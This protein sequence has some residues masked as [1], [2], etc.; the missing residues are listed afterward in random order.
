MTSHI[1]PGCRRPPRCGHA[2]ATGPA[3]ELF[4]E[5]SP[6]ARF[7]LFLENFGFRACLRSNSCDLFCFITKSCIYDICPLPCLCSPTLFCAENRPSPTCAGE[8]STKDKKVITVLEKYHPVPKIWKCALMDKDYPFGVPRLENFDCGLLVQFDL[9]ISFSEIWIM[10]CLKIFVKILWWNNT[11][12][13]LSG[14]WIELS[15]VGAQT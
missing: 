12:L 13:L 15:E 3:W 8:K 2:G 14:F 10:K 4:W 5:T 6:R 11:Y 1:G 7:Q 9:K